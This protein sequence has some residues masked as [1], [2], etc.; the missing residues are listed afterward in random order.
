MDGDCEVITGYAEFEHLNVRTGNPHFEG[1][2]LFFLSSSARES[3]CV[4]TK[5]AIN[6]EAISERFSSSSLAGLVQEEEEGDEF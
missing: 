5:G 4:P 1:A 3:L 6:S 2:H